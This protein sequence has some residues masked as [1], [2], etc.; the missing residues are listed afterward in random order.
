MRIASLNLLKIYLNNMN[1]KQKTPSEI[2]DDYKQT[3]DSIQIILENSRKMKFE[4]IPKWAENLSI[5]ELKSH[6]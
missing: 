1:I 6:S 3:I 4:S 2:F 5:E